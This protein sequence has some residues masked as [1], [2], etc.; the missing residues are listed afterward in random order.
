MFNDNSVDH[1]DMNKSVFIGNGT[2]LKQLD[3]SDLNLTFDQDYIEK[4]RFK[5][6]KLFN[7]CEFFRFINKNFPEVAGDYYEISN[8]LSKNISKDY[9]ALYL[10]YQK[11]KLF[12]ENI[13]KQILKSNELFLTDDNLINICLIL[14]RAF[15]YSKQ[16]GAVNKTNFFYLFDLDLQVLESIKESEKLKEE[17]MQIYTKNKC[18]KNEINDRKKI[19]IFK[20][21]TSLF[22]FGKSSSGSS[23]ENENSNNGFFLNKEL[24]RKNKHY[25]KAIHED[26]T[27][28]IESLYLVKS[29]HFCLPETENKFAFLF[30]FFINFELLLPNIYQINLD[31]EAKISNLNAVNVGILIKIRFILSFDYFLYLNFFVCFF[32]FF[33]IHYK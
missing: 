29:V 19:T 4:K 11:T 13:C 21:L 3:K 2:S 24:L 27:N 28:L 5:S 30:L 1:S 22:T 12:L 25:N 14:A 20:S 15:I 8:N 23:N 18:K 33:Y 31:F 10:N 26:L 32:Y 7:K 6:L 17:D 9:K 16:M